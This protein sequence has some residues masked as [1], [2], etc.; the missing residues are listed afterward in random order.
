M[1]DN[2]RRKLRFRA[3]HRGIREMDLFMEAFADA[4][5]ETMT[6]DDLDAFERLLDVPDQEVYSWITGNI[7]PPAEL[8][9]RVLDLVLRFRYPAPVTDTNS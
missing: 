6:E 9:S 4:H 7:S 2:R 5:L 8:R 3:G 1:L